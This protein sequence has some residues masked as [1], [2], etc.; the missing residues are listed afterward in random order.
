[1]P[2][3]IGEDIG[4]YHVVEQLGEGGMAS[5]FK[6]FDTHLERYVALK[7]I[8]PSQQQTEQFLKRFDREA[9]ALAKLTH[10]NIVPVIDYGEYKDI[11]FLVMAFIPGGT[12]RDMMGSAIAWDDAARLIAPIASALAYAHRSGIIHRDVKPANIL[13]TESGQPM[14]SDFG[15]AKI[16]ETKTTALTGTGM[17]IGT[18]DYMCPEQGQG[19][20]VD[21]RSDVYSLGV[22]FY[23]MITGRKPFIADTPL[24]VVVKHMTE[25]LPRPKKFV[26]D[27][28]DGVEAVIFKALAKNPDDRYV[29]MSAFQAALEKLGRGIFPIEPVPQWEIAPSQPAT[30]VQSLGE[31]QAVKTPPKPL[32]VTQADAAS[33]AP[34]RAPVLQTQPAAPA[35]NLLQKTSAAVGEEIALPL[36][37]PQAVA[38]RSRSLPVWL[39]LLGGF[40]ILGICGV[41]VYAGINLVQQRGS[42]TN[43]P[44]AS[45]VIS[46]ITRT[47]SSSTQEPQMTEVTTATLEAEIIPT[48]FS[49]A[50][51]VSPDPNTL[52]IV[53]VSKPNTMDPALSYTGDNIGIISN[54][55]ETLVIANPFDRMEMLPMLAESWEVS[56]DGLTYTFHIREGVVFQNGNLLTAED[57]AYSIQRGILQGN[58]GAGQ[59]IVLEPLAGSGITDISQLV[60]SSG[61]LIDD[62]ASIR[63]ADADL[64][65]SACL[66]LKQAVSANDASQTVTITLA[67]PWSPFLSILAAPY[68]SIMDK[69]WTINGG[70]W[71]GSCE[72]WQNFYA[73]MALEESPFYTQANGT[74]PFSLDHWDVQNGQIVLARNEHYWLKVPRWEGGR[75][76]P[77]TFSRVVISYIDDSSTRLAMMQSGAADIAD[78][79]DVESTERNQLIG[80]ICSSDPLSQ[81]LTCRQI[82]DLPMRQLGPLP[83]ESYSALFFS[84][85]PKPAPD[86]T[87]F[88]GSGQLDGNGIPPDFFS[89]V[90]IRRAFAY[91]INYDAV[92]EN[93]NTDSGVGGYPLYSFALPGSEGYDPNVPHFEF[94]LDKCAEEFQSS[95]WPDLWNTGFYM[96]A[97]A[98]SNSSLQNHLLAS[99]RSNLVQ[100]NSR[101]ILETVN[102]SMSEFVSY[103][104]SGSL[105]IM[106]GNWA[107]DYFDTYQ[108]PTAIVNF[109]PYYQNAPDGFYTEASQILQSA[110]GQLNPVARSDLYKQLNL[111]LFENVPAVPVMQMGQIFYMQRWMDGTMQSPLLNSDHY[112]YSYWKH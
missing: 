62:S 83:L 76:G 44:S 38:K 75:T 21:S 77:A 50:G 68:T 47:S 67:F 32:V 13:I 52:N 100:V 104:N 4:R 3:L 26:P 106:A 71:D 99:L 41:L 110:A 63:E 53:K 59:G 19:L 30:S 10:S 65:R 23:E 81:S 85:S 92:I 22:V 112:F 101:F 94:D 2:T 64:L 103:R 48:L 15:I 33:A 73:P 16:L 102:V 91:C 55:Y 96:R 31:T 5:V 7:I 8:L 109:Y 58:S 86:G 97:A 57:V 42:K 46:Q 40:G 56:A 35:Q 70:G 93:F 84:F 82:S 29:D 74:G 111:W 95:H 17:G 49:S 20:P 78:L 24:A 27:L 36:P 14:L 69:D 9:K 37:A 105:P 12:L 51:F 45:Q 6:A 87:N 80:E 88:L 43:T 25:P 54:V 89:D 66:K 11:P 61:A 98:R 79:S 60:D 108:F 107:V 72:T 90:H 18:P 39:Y 28:P 1:M 34:P